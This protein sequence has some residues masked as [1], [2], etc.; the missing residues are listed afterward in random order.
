[1]RGLNLKSQ[2]S[3]RQSC[4]AAVTALVA[5]STLL[6]LMFSTSHGAQ[7]NPAKPLA[8]GTV[9]TSVDGKLLAGGGD[10]WI[11]ELI[12][13]TNSISG[14]VATGTRFELLPCMT[15]E[16]LIADVNDRYAPTYRL[17]ARVT[18]FR[19][20]G[21][22]FPTYYLPL[23]KLK[24]ATASGV[25]SEGPRTLPETIKNDQ[26]DPE[27]TIPK[28]VAEK[29]R[30]RRMVR[31]PQ[32]EGGGPESKRSPDRVIV[33]A[34]G[35]IEP[36]ASGLQPPAS[37]DRFVFVPDAFGWNI[38]QTRYEL[39]PCGVLEQALQRQAASPEPIR[40]NVAGLVTEFKGK[41]YLL[42][43]RAMR[44]YGHGNFVK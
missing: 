11:F 6:I 35:R 26:S 30:N 5:C 15:L 33:D 31:G 14:V 16:L 1:V 25:Q 9:L 28:E 20:K 32:R 27:L 2:I 7:Q 13:D 22:L 21:F 23:S 10:T 36:A 34:I 18:R 39:L 38:A 29:L 40:F 17:S 19:G 37:P 12:A 4:R 41:Q 44:A 43:Q 8:D 3:N 42:L 24:S